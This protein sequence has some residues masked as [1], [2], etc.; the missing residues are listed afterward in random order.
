[1]MNAKLLVRAVDY[2]AC[3]LFRMTAAPFLSGSSYLH[4]GGGCVMFKHRSQRGDK[5]PNAANHDEM[6]ADTIL[7]EIGG[8]VG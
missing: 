2:R 5:S 7:L 3:P 6:Q 8:C 4:N 1:M